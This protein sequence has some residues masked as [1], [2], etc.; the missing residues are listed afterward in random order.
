MERVPKA[1]QAWALT[2]VSVSES[3]QRTVW[4]LRRQAPEKPE[5]GSILAPRS[6]AICPVEAR[7][8]MALS[9]ASAIA[10]PS[11]PVIEKARSETSCR[12]SSKAN[13]SSWLTLADSGSPDLSRRRLACSWMQAKASRAWRAL[14]PLSRAESDWLCCG[15]GAA[16]TPFGG[17]GAR[18]HAVPEL[19][20]VALIV[21][22]KPAMVANSLPSPK[23]RPKPWLAQSTQYS[24]VV[25]YKGLGATAIFLF[26]AEIPLV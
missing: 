19:F 22:V 15:V 16:E 10:T 9:S 23:L 4:P 25:R 14:R 20:G 24:Y 8:T 5:V 26:G 2:R 12:T 17:S 7:Q 11:A 1:R 3:S 13:S 6:G 18:L 21:S